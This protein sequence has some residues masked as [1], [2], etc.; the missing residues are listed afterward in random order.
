MTYPGTCKCL[1]LTLNVGKFSD[2]FEYVPVELRLAERNYPVYITVPFQ[3]SSMSD[4]NAGTPWQDMW[5]TKNR[6]SARID[7]LRGASN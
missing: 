4:I 5:T 1:D 3:C 7:D 2:A 6:I